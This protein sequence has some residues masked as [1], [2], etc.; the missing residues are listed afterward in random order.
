MASGSNEP[1][2]EE[3]WTSPDYFGV[4]T[5]TPLQRG[6]CRL[7]DGFELGDLRNHPD[8]QLAFGVDDTDLIPAW[9]RE[10]VVLAG[11]RTGKSRM[12]AAWAYRQARIVDVSKLAPGEIARL[13]CISL[14]KDL[15]SVLYNHILG[16]VESSPLMAKHLVDKD[17]ETIVI[18]NISGRVVEI[19]VV[20]GKRAGS[21]LVARWSAGCIFDEAPRMLGG[22]DAIVNLDHCRDAVLGRILPGSRL[23]HIGSP[24][25]DYGPVHEMHSAHFGNPSRKCVVA[26]AKAWLMNPVYWT[27][28]RCE[29]LREDDPDVHET[30]VEA[31]FSSG[32]ENLYERVLLTQAQRV[33]PLIVP[34]DRTF[35][36]SF[37]M[38]PATRGNAWTLVGCSRVGPSRI[39]VIGTWEW[40]GTSKEPLDPGEV[41]RDVASIVTEYDADSV[42]TDQWSFD[43]LRVIASGYGIN[44]YESP[45]IQE[46]GTYAMYAEVRNLLRMGG[47]ELSPEQKLFDDLKAVK[48][49]PGKTGGFTVYLPRNGKN[50]HCDYAPSLVI[51]A[52]GY[53]AMPAKTAEEESWKKGLDPV[54]I[55]EQEAFV[56]E[57]EQVEQ[58]LGGD[59]EEFYY[60]LYG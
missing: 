31:N 26:K 5:A 49:K 59:D 6:L 44:L 19:K 10:F 27:N 36:T 38:D 46:A 16:T 51:A 28:E 43:S 17:G 13:S 9:A 40:V 33:A 53:L 24:F 52:T 39:R 15:A 34:Y 20:A 8:I 2:L 29:A 1:T 37:A 11:I 56:S 54:E 42:M 58:M 41:L 23:L 3:L 12:A 4:T 57:I 18:R 30:D 45:W 21:S 47:L 22:S 55:A 32:E 60:E 7:L 35:S 50:R 25:G 48:K 14:S